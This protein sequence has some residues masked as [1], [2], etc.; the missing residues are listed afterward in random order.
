MSSGDYYNT[1][2]GY[3]NDGYR[4]STV[5]TK[6]SSI[7]TS[8]F[9]VSEGNCVTSTY[10]EK[11]KTT[12]SALAKEIDRFKCALIPSN[13]IN[14]FVP[15]TSIASICSVTR[16]EPSSAPIL[17]PTLPAQIKAVTKGPRAL[18]NAIEIKEGNHEEAPNTSNEGLDCLVK[19]TP[20]TKPVSVINGSDFNPTS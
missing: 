19:T 7:Q 17:E 4:K 18:T 14:G 15:E 5:Y 13:W 2:F 3:D 1:N 20:V 6:P 8:N 12:N 9:I 10:E 11:S 16:I